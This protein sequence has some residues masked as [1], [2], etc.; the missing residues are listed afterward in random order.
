MVVNYEY[1]YSAIVF[2]PRRPF[3][4]SPM[5]VR[6]VRGL[7]NLKGTSLRK[8]PALLANIRLVRDKYFI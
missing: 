7:P 2:V 3:K 1:S 4:P 8:V 5:F 6:K